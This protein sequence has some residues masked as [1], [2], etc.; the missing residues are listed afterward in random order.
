MR[1]NERP[2]SSA[3]RSSSVSPSSRSTA[4]AYATT[5][6]PPRSMSCKASLLAT[7]TAIHALLVADREADAMPGFADRE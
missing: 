4:T 2:R 5:G 3:A 7:K 6:R 1:S